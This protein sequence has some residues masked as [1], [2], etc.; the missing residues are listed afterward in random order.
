MD[1]ELVDI[2]IIINS[3]ISGKYKKC[4][5]G[6]DEDTEQ[7]S[8]LLLVIMQIF[9]ARTHILGFVQTAKGVEQDTLL[10]YPIYAL[11]ECI[12]DAQTMLILPVE[13]YDKVKNDENIY[14]ATIDKIKKITN[15]HS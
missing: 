7:S 9:I 13:M 8:T 4:Y 15:L 3:F 11:E 2:D 10:E 12:V 5:I 1:R 6:L 14:T